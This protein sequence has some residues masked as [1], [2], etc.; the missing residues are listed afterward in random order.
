MGEIFTL[1]AGGL[2]GLFCSIF[3]NLVTGPIIEATTRYRL[4]VFLH[5]LS[6]FA[7]STELERPWVVAWQ[8]DEDPNAGEFASQ[9]SAIKTFFNAVGFSAIF[10]IY[11]EDY[12][13]HFI[14]R[15][16]GN[17]VSGSWYDPRSNSGYHGQFQV[18]FNGLIEG[19]A[20]KWVGWSTAGQVKSGVVKINQ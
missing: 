16:S 18:I 5:A 11:G 12:E 2:I 17:I 7:R 8:V 15:K 14:G 19:A 20:G 9:I 3:A 4:L 1:F 10:K 6:P 13:Y